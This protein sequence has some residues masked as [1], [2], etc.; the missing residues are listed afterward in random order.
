MLQQLCRCRNITYLKYIF[1]KKEFKTEK[2]QTLKDVKLETKQLEEISIFEL[3]CSKEEAELYN[4]MFNI[5]TYNEDAYS[6]NKFGHYKDG[7]RSKGFTDKTD[8]YQTN[9]KKITEKVKKI[10]RKNTI[11]LVVRT[12]FIKRL[13]NI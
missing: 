11:I 7:L 10:N 6:T 13:M 3:M 1:Y 4:S 9:K 8:Y 2:Y 5:I 12:L